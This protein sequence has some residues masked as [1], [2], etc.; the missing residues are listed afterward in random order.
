MPP[1]YTSI[2]TIAR[3]SAASNTYKPATPQKVNRRKN[4]AW[5]MFLVVTTKPADKTTISAKR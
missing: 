2:C 4:A 1:T 3:K 5:T